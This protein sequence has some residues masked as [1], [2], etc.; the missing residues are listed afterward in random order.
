MARSKKTSLEWSQS[1]FN[2]F[3]SDFLKATGA[4]TSV[5]LKKFVFDLMSR[6]IPR[7]PVDTG[8]ARAGWGAAGKALGIEVPTKIEG[9][10]EVKA[11]TRRTASGK[12]AEVDA[13]IRN[14]TA[15]DEGEYEEKLTGDKQFIRI[16]NNVQYILPL[17]YGHSAQAPFGMVRISMAEL[18][19]HRPIGEEL[20]GHYAK[21][22]KSMTDKS[23]YKI[24]G[25]VLKDVFGD[26][27]NVPLPKRSAK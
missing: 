15:V 23:R 20:M 2:G 21:R 16:A 3:I 6:V 24:Q 13:Y 14:A 18:R 19:S 11:H 10:I 25:Y 7:T 5:V 1:K 9:A 26:L 22:W 27:K 4:D 8:R 17:E 12:L